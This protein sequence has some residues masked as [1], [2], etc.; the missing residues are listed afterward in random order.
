M[1]LYKLYVFCSD[2]KFKMAATAGLSLTLDPKGKMFQN[3]SSLK[4]LGQLKPNC[5]G[6]SH[7]KVLYKVYVFYA[8]RKSKMA[9]TAIHRLTLDPMGKC[10]NAFFSET[11]NI[12][13]AKLYMNVHWMVLYKLY[14]FCSDMK[15]KM[16]ATAGLNLTLD[17]M[18]KMFQN[19]SSLKPLGQLKPNC[20][21]MIIGRSSTRCVFFMPIGYPRWPPP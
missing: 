15:F 2:M 21:G 18:G 12:I 1:V 19:A 9:A 3:A 10:S 8:D 11:T 20:P 17:P 14:V 6:M 4:P 5:P 7:W 13:K 16:A